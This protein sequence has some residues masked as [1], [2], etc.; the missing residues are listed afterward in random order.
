M[1]KPA[2]TEAST[3]TCRSEPM[4]SVVP[5]RSS[6]RRW[7]CHDVDAMAQRLHRRATALWRNPAHAGRLSRIAHRLERRAR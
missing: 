5:A 7:A 4:P 1:A 3:M 6:A 2:M